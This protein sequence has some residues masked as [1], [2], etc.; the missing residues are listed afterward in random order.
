MSVSSNHRADRHRARP[1]GAPRLTDPASGDEPSR[2]PPGGGVARARALEPPRAAATVDQARPAARA[3][4]TVVRRRIYGPLNG[5][6]GYWLQSVAGPAGA[7]A[8]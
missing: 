7:G 3:P 2:R 5:A 6:T 1:R 8:E 4:L